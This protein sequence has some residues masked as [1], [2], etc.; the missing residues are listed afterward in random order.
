MVDGNVEKALNLGCVKVDQE[1]AVGAGGGQEGGDQLRGNSHS[2]SV[3]AVLTSVAVVGDDH[4][5]S[6]GGSAL[7]RVHHDEELHDVL[8]DRVACG[9]DE[10]HIHTTHVFK[11]LKVDLTVGEAL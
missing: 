3:F 7:E 2:G 6:A 11:E 9:L 1:G 5:D 4:R 8:V 10:E